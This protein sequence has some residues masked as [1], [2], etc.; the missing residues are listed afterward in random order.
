MLAATLTAVGTPDAKPDARVLAAE[1]PG[2]SVAL[3]VGVLQGVA[4]APTYVYG[5]GAQGLGYY[6]VPAQQ[7]VQQTQPAPRAAAPRATAATAP[8]RHRE[9]GTGRSVPLAKP[10]LNQFR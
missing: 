7:Q 3:V 4:A 9:F 10:W 6:V 1:A 8:R 5:H 2:L